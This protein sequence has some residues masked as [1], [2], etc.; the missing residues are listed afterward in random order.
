MRSDRAKNNFETLKAQHLILQEAHRNLTAEHQTVIE[1]YE[2]LHSRS[3]EIISTLQKERDG[4]IVE[5]E[6]L[7]SQVLT[8]QKIEQLKVELLSEVEE[9]YRKRMDEVE[10]Q[11]ESL[12]SEHTKLKYSYA[13]LKS[14]YE[15]T[16][17]NHQVAVDEMMAKHNAELSACI[18]ERKD[19]LVQHD[20][21]APSDLHTIRQLQRENSELQQRAKSLLSGMEELQEQRE[22]A[23]LQNEQSLQRCSRQLAEAQAMLKTLEIER[24]SLSSQ[25]QTL[26]L[27]LTS[28]QELQYSLN[29]QL[30][31]AQRELAT[32]KRR[33]DELEHKHLMESGEIRMQAHQQV[34]DLQQAKEKLATELRSAHGR[35]ESLQSSLSE[36]DSLLAQREQEIEHRVQ[37][38]REKEWEK[39]EVLQKEKVDLEEKLADL[40]RLHSE[41][42][43]E[44]LKMVE[45]SDD[46]LRELQ[47]QKATSDTE[48]AS[49]KVRLQER[50]EQ[51]QT[52]QMEL[53]QLSGIN[54]KYQTLV[55]EHTSL[56]Q[57]EQEAV[58][59][60]D[61]LQGSVQ[62]LEE[63]IA[64][65][66]ADTQGQ[67]DAHRQQLER[68]R[69]S[70]KD[71]KDLLLS[72]AEDCE[73]KRL[74]LV[75]ELQK[76]KKLLKKYQKH[77]K[78]CNQE[79]KMAV[80]VQTAKECQM[81][82]EK[83][84]LR[85]T[86]SAENQKLRRRLN[87]IQRRQKEFMFV[88]HHEPLA[89]GTEHSIPAFQ[90]KRYFQKEMEAVNSRID[91]LAA[92]HSQ[93]YRF[94]P[95]ASPANSLS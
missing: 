55:A 75:E 56:K 40:Q 74:S 5:C 20:H 49:V 23:G 85:K 47:L 28:A 71:E 65:L 17:A 91:E 38:V 39:M 27:E 95:S 16:V 8:A 14:E 60:A 25:V 93:S 94:A 1:N 35:V 62:L 86:M 80:E 45:K 57:S 12:R 22:K 64:M 33:M 42:E 83:E 46:Q 6:E 78:K 68:E 43:R 58:R 44:K 54:K 48:L 73:T 51:C 89:S 9:P 31:Q 50:V 11:L 41:A 81:E 69:I 26:Q 13:F 61:K 19:R 70:W 10:S 87:D 37:L 7:R 24:S 88:L 66:Q 32:M 82:A 90:E 72:K 2:K 30:N 77:Y 4:K 53:R 34:S 15:A 36:R 76:A 3:K 92:T 21:D 18:G 84:A 29:D 59:V 63:H 79:L 67:L 52:V